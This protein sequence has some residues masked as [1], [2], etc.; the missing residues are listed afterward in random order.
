MHAHV[1]VRVR[2]PLP[3]SQ[4]FSEL[5]RTIS[6]QY[7]A[8]EGQRAVLQAQELLQ[9][10]LRVA[11]FRNLPRQRCGGRKLVKH[12]CPSR[13]Q[14]L[15]WAKDF[16]METRDCGCYWLRQRS[17]GRHFIRVQFCPS[18]ALSLSFFLFVPVQ[19]RV[20]LCVR[21]FVRVCVF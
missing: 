5:W 18:V 15:Q 10:Q 14:C 7:G 9:H 12:G 8:P 6:G 3:L 21:E 19:S 4:L 20:F 16:C 13:N 1:C 2:A 11:S 17:W